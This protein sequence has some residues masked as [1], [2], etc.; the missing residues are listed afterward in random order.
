MRSNVEKLAQSLQPWYN[1]N[2]GASQQSFRRDKGV[3]HLKRTLIDDNPLNDL[4]WVK[5]FILEGS[6]A[7]SFP[8]GRLRLENRLDPSLQQK[9]NYVF[10]CPED[11]PSDIAITWDFWPVREPGLAL[12]FF[13]A[14]GRNG[15]DLFD[16]ALQKRTGEYPLYHHGDINAFHISYFRRK[17]PDERAFHTYNLRKSYGFYMAAQGGDPIPDVAS[18]VPPYHLTVMKWGPDVTFSVND[19]TV[20]HY[21][22]DGVTYGP[23]LTGGKIGFRQ[24]A[25]MIGEYANLKVYALE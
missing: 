13:A 17:E 12:L 16:P 23:L 21:H 25:P 24:L 22:D 6:A 20:L 19:L 18:A 3:I 5:D 2:A 14:K 15:E 11:F 1:R 4:A 8:Q 7:L 10:W 9:A